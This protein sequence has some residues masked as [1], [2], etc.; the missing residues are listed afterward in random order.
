MY[1]LQYTMITFTSHCPFI[2]SYSPPLPFPSLP[3]PSLPF[4]SLPFPSLPFPSLPF[5]FFSFLFFSF[6]FFS[7]LFFSMSSFTF[8][9][10][11]PFQVP[12]R[13]PLS[14]PHSPC[15][16]EGAYPPTHSHPPSMT[17]PYTGALNTLRPKGLS[18]H[19]CATRPS[20]APY[21]ASGMGRSMCIVWLL[22]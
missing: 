10:F 12:F 8:Q 16:Y 11:S 7:F 17:F 4:P 15:L 5:P 2:I 22:W 19:W 14:T 1:S 3:F 6:L 9:M 13:D 20:S 21:V 18:S